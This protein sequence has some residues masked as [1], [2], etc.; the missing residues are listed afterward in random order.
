MPENKE[1]TTTFT[2]ADTKI[3]PETVQTITGEDDDLLAKI[4]HLK[5]EL[6][7][8]RVE[9]EQAYHRAEIR[10]RDGLIEGLRYAIRC[11]GVSG[12]DVR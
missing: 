7:S 3:D 10:Y 9:R 6:D 1:W 2:S 5:R 4:E 12:A 11:N 8:A